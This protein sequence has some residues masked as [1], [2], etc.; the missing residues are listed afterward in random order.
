MGTRTTALRLYGKMDL[1]LETFEL[2]EPKEDEILAEVVCDSLCMS[3]YKAAKQGTEHKRVH[4]DLAQNPAILGHEF[5]GR[6]LKVGTRWGKQF[7]EGDKFGIQPALNYKGT[8][9]APGYS[10]PTCGGDTTHVVIPSCV[11]EME[12]LLRYEGEAYFLA[13]LAEP[14]SCIIGACKA[15][16]HV[17]RG[18]YTHRMGIVERGKAALLGAAGPMGLGMVD[19]LIHGPRRPK[20]VVVTD[21]DEGRLAH[22]RGILAPEQAK[23]DGVELRYVN[24]GRGEPVKE[25]LGLSGGE[26]YDDVFVFAAVTSVVEQG[27]A[28]LGKDGC[29]NFFAGP[30]AAD[31]S[32]RVNF[33]DVHYAGTHLVGTTGGNT[34]D[35]RD[36]LDLM[37]QGKINPAMMITHVGGLSAAKEAT[38][39]LPELAGWKKLIYTHVDTPLVAI[40]DF[41]ERGK[42]DPL[43]AQLAEICGRHRGMW[44]LEAERLFLSKAPKLSR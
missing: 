22:A 41:A 10:F 20:M 21:I 38:L 40:A 29:L 25:L 39:H 23:R 30:T 31:F 43:F 33:F 4:A 37:T 6:I 36:A 16:Y 2:P 17:T 26:G 34:E 42:V 12:C 3:S 1:R 7:R 19:Y 5:S 18:T 32:A 24:T 27:D 15:Q 9:D 13:S 8:L 35:I 14:M 11:M 44:S 28:L